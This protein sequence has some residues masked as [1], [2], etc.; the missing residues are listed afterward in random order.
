MDR[1]AAEFVEA[2]YSDDPAEK[3]DTLQ[4]HVEELVTQRLKKGADERAKRELTKLVLAVVKQILDEG[5]CSSLVDIKRLSGRELLA[6]LIAEVLDS[7][8]PR[9]MAASIDFTFGLGVQVG[10]N[11]TQIAAEHDVT[12]AS[13][14]RYCRHL[15]EEYL[16]GKPSAGMK[17]T[18]AVK[19][20]RS[21]R[22]GRSSR[23]PRTEWPFASVLKSNYER[24]TATHT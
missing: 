3:C 1:D 9:L 10:K 5:R 16:G 2:S 22:T 12:K 21:L 13:V 11:E 4:D 24:P 8:N 6:R 18:D 20:Y 19:N 15:V 23:A 14:S 17:S 7:P